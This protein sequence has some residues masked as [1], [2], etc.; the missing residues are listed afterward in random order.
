MRY[1]SEGERIPV[2]AMLCEYPDATWT[3]V[4]PGIENNANLPDS[5]LKAC[6]LISYSLKKG[7]KN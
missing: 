2:R 7:R 5:N 1:K 4:L 6:V 3:I